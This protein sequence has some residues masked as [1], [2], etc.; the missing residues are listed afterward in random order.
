MRQ[1]GGS[2]DCKCGYT[3]KGIRIRDQSKRYPTEV[4]S[5]RT[6]DVLGSYR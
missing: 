3:S 5:E 6:P 4:E 2:H 1:D